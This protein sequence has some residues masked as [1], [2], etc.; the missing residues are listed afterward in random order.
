M[1]SATGLFLLKITSITVRDRI[2]ELQPAADHEVGA[3]RTTRAR[4]HAG[5]GHF[6]L[7][8]KA[9]NVILLILPCRLCGEQL[10][11]SIVVHNC[12][13][14]LVSIWLANSVEFWKLC[15]MVILLYVLCQT[16]SLIFAQAAFTL[17]S[18]LSIH[19]E[20]AV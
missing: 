9:D 3:P 1:Y 13:P 6:L 20:I 16:S 8:S 17:L 2:Q 15:M 5:K 4:P 19:R 10:R 7:A 12:K 18:R 11:T 14:L